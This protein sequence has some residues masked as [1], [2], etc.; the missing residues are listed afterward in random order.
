MYVHT[1]LIKAAES[2]DQVAA[3]LAREMSHVALRHGA[4]QMSK[5]Q[6]WGIVMGGVLSSEDCRPLIWCSGLRANS[7]AEQ[8]GRRSSAENRRSLLSATQLLIC[9]DRRFS[10]S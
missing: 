8:E 9:L 6:T 3:V 7:H 2:E 5:Q 1:G 4:N 10:N